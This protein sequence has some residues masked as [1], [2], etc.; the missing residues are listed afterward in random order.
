MA[1]DL[2]TSVQLL[3]HRLA[4]VIH[5]ALA[6][7]ETTV[8]DLAKKIG[9]SEQF[10]WRVLS[11]RDGIAKVVKVSFLANVAW[12]LGCE[13]HFALVPIMPVETDAAVEPEADG[14]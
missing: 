12:A 9:E 4:S 2:E 7:S 11:A 14:P 1:T 13:V 5:G 3:N 6:T 8:P 10:I